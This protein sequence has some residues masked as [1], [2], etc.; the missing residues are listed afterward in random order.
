MSY[1]VWARASTSF[2]YATDDKASPP[3]AWK[4][5]NTTS[6]ESPAAIVNGPTLIR[7]RLSAEAA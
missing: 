1:A 6:C 2:K 3:A 4:I 5:P 7:K